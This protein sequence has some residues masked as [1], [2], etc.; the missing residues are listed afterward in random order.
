MSVFIFDITDFYT[1]YHFGDDIEAN[2]T[3]DPSKLKS[4]LP[5]YKSYI[6]DDYLDLNCG[7]VIIRLIQHSNMQIRNEVVILNGKRILD[8][9]G[10]VVSPMPTKQCR[11]RT[12]QSIKPLKNVVKKEFKRKITETFYSKEDSSEHV[13]EINGF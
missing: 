2:N 5:M 12:I 10:F 9:N 4:G 8:A 7:G 3:H 6:G 13:M 1:L 11:V